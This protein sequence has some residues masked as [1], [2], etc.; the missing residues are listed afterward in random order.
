[1]DD[2]VTLEF[3]AKAEYVLLGRL[4]LAGMLVQGEFSSDAVADLKLALTEACSN[5]IRHAYAD[6]QGQIRLG[7]RVADR[8]LVLTVRD[9]GAGFDDS[10]EQTALFAPGMD[11][12]SLPEGG[13]GFSIIRA[14]VDDFSLEHPSA[15][16][17]LLTLT[18]RFDL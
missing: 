5:S 10:E 15:G 9:E 12:V 16:G 13:M 7:F 11:R 3:P 1:M 17:T 8:C 14:V 6:G 4:A 18:K 2:L